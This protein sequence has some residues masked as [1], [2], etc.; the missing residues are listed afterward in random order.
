M[1]IKSLATSTT[2]VAFLALSTFASSSALGDA[3]LSVEQLIPQLDVAQTVADKV[4]D[5]VD[6]SAL[7]AI[8]FDSIR[9]LG[10]DGV[11]NYWV[12]RVGTSQLCLIMHI[13]NGY[14]VSAAACGEISDFHQQG[15]GLRAGESVNESERSAEAYL[16]PSDV[17]PSAIVAKYKL[18]LREGT[19]A[20]LL[21]VTPGSLSAE[22]ITI[23]RMGSS[24]FSF[25]PL[26]TERGVEVQ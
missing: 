12:G 8:D 2:L 5:V 10:T 18:E 17:Q 4:P 22:T 15:I 25:V 20:G 13:P 7:G 6:L 19:N 14:E 1:R 23:P 11:A 21:A 16:L 9:S 26:S 24:D 3:H